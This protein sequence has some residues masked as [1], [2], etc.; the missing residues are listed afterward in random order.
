MKAFIFGFQGEGTLALIRLDD[1]F[2]RLHDLFL[3]SFKITD[4]KPLRE[5]TCPGQQEELLAKKKKPNS[6]QRMW[7]I[8]GD[9]F[10]QCESSHPWLFSKHQDGKNSPLQLPP[11]NPP[12]KI[13]GNIW[14]VAGRA[15]DRFWLQIRDFF[16]Y[17]WTLEKKSLT[18]AGGHKKLCE[19]F[20]VTLS[21]SPFFSSQPEA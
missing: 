2:I 4:V 16:S 12:A 20:L 17:L 5:M 8:C 3:E 9:I 18:S 13:Y 11:G 14:A 7:H 21:L 15:A 10:S 19:E 1:L 6:P